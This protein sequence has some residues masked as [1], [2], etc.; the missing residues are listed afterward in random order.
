MQEPLKLSFLSPKFHPSAVYRFR[1][2]ALGRSVCRE[3]CFMYMG[4]GI[5]L[6]IDLLPSSLFIK[7]KEQ[8]YVKNVL[9]DTYKC[10]C[11]GS[12]AAI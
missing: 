5:Y 2:F 10:S 3:T 6:Q 1:I 8:F 12:G 4:M 7:V 11:G 9:Q